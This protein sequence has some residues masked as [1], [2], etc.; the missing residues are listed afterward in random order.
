MMK[1]SNPKVNI[2]ESTLSVTFSIKSDDGRRLAVLDLTLMLEP[3]EQCPMGRWYYFNR[4]NVPTG[5]IPANAT[6]WLYHT[7]TEW[8]D[9]NNVHIYND[10]APYPNSKLDAQQIMTFESLYGFKELTDHQHTTIRLAN[11]HA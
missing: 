3:P 4:V 11:S 10:I 6:L 8:A 2:N 5:F 7:M 9:T 1:P